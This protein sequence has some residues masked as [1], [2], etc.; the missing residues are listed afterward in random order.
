MI[1]VG[2]YE[3]Q[4]DFLSKSKQGDDPQTYMPSFFLLANFA[5]DFK[6]KEDPGSC[7]TSIQLT[8]TLPN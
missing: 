2:G 5:L 1:T 4:P 7:F 6:S 8:H 3:P